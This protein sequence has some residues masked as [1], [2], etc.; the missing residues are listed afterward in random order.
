MKNRNYRSGIVLLI[1][2]ALLLGRAFNVFIITSSVFKIVLTVL[3][4]WY[5]LTSLPRRRYVGV[6]MPLTFAYLINE[7]EIMRYIGHTSVNPWLLLWGAF[8]LALALET[9]FKKRSSFN[10][11]FDREDYFESKKRR[12]ND[13]VVDV[14][15][16]THSDEETDGDAA[17]TEG[18]KE[19]QTNSSNANPDFVRIESNFGDRT[20]YVRVDNFTDGVIEA[21][22]GSL[23][24]YFDQTTFNPEGSHL[25]VECNLGKVILFIPR[26]VN[27]VNRVSSTMGAVS[28]PMAFEGNGPVLTITGDVALG[29]LRIVYL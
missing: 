19:S 16:T 3:L 10:V 24:V 25:R 7:R 26:S 8:F 4:V 21:N 28:D 6:I 11:Y 23:R 20:R 14:K 22:L 17:Q 2:S 9:I 27:V 15:S 12:Y 5:S 1:I 18:V 13:D 29:N